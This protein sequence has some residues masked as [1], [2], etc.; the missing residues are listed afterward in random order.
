VP[1]APHAGDVGIPMAIPTIDLSEYLKKRS[2]MR[3]LPNLLDLAMA[4]ALFRPIF[5]M[6]HTAI[7]RT[8][9]RSVLRWI[10]TNSTVF[11]KV[12]IGYFAYAL[13]VT[14]IQISITAKL[15]SLVLSDSRGSVIVIA[16]YF[17]LT[18]LVTSRVTADLTVMSV[19]IAL[20]S[21]AYVY[22]AI[23]YSRKL[24][25]LERD[26]VYRDLVG[27]RR[28]SLTYAT[29]RYAFVSAESVKV[30]AL[31][32]L[33]SWK[34]LLAYVTFCAIV[35]G[36]RIGLRLR[37]TAGPESWLNW[38]PGSA[39]ILMFI[40]LLLVLTLVWEQV[41]SFIS[42]EVLRLGREL[43][44][45]L[46]RSASALAR[47][48][49]RPPILLLRSF[50]DD[51]VQ[52]QKDKYWGQWL[53][54][55]RDD[56]VRLEEIVAETLYPYGPLIALSNPG[57]ELAPIGAARENIRGS[58]WQHAVEHHMEETSEIVMIV[59]TTPS[60]RWE[61]QQLITKGLLPRCVFV[62]PPEY[63]HRRDRERCLVNCLPELARELDLQSEEAE[64]RMLSNVLLIGGLGHHTQVMITA[65]SGGGAIDYAE[66]LRLFM[67]HAQAFKAD[68]FKSVG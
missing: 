62:F 59:G 53:L 30:F 49:P 51:N 3:L 23:S 27:V 20:G 40:G 36:V 22:A 45:E 33:R 46:A 56:E 50:R 38:A 66:A 42:N 43:R 10:E 35:L 39:Q 21:A 52:V 28:N 7:G 9:E 8:L 65:S 26:P 37:Q 25:S 57:E 19:A 63:R 44:R 2:E 64:I 15:K 5:Q 61:L 48:D 18:G 54:G 68:M 58:A 32:L 47:K 16:A 31:T 14:A 55:I 6:D 67:E 1:L 12:A 4:F 41:K 60:L 29:A 24:S 13:A 17:L 11:I 34:V